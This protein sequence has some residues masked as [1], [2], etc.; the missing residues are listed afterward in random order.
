MSLFAGLSLLFPSFTRAAALRRGA[1][2]LAECAGLDENLSVLADEIERAGRAFDVPTN[3]THIVGYSAGAVM[4]VTLVTRALLQPFGSA[5][6]MAG[7]ILQPE[8]VGKAA[9]DTPILLRHNRDD[10][11]FDWDE[12]YV[13]MRQAL[14]DNGYRVEA[15]EKNDG[16]H[17]VS[18]YD[19]RSLRKFLNRH[20][21]E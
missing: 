14:R 19:V 6:V 9:C 1:R 7:A 8:R 16:N 5:F 12:R 20:I 2:V 4:G 17:G 15:D 13:P 18:G 10:A 11:C 3:R 21:V